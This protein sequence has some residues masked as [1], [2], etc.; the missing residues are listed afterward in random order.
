MLTK[1]DFL[2]AAEQEIRSNPSKYSQLSPLLQAGDP[3]LTQAIGSIATML[4]MLSQ[5]I[6]ASTDEQFNRIKKSTVDAWLASH[7][8]WKSAKAATFKVR[9]KN[10]HPTANVLLNLFTQLVSD[11][12]V[13]CRTMDRRAYTIEPNQSITVDVGQYTRRNNN[14]DFVHTVT[15]TKPFY[16]IEIPLEED[17]EYREELLVYVNDEGWSYQADYMNL[18]P[19]DKAYTLTV[20]STGRLVVQFGDDALGGKMLKAGD[21]VRMNAFTTKGADHGIRVGTKMVTENP[22]DRGATL[23]FEVIEITY[24]GD[25]PMSEEAKAQ[26]AKYPALYDS[27][28]VYLGEFEAM[29]RRKMP[30]LQFLSIWNEMRHEEATGTRDVKN[31]NCLFVAALN[32]NGGGFQYGYNDNARSTSV[33]FSEITATQMALPNSQFLYEIEKII[34]EADD[35]YRVRFWYPCAINPAITVNIE[36]GSSFDAEQIRTKAKQVIVKRYGRYYAGTQNRSPAYP[37]RAIRRRDIVNMIQ[38][39]C[40]E[41]RAPGS[42]IDVLVDDPAGSSSHPNIYKWVR[43]QDITIN[44]KTS[45]LVGV[46]WGE[47]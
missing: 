35:S 25:N 6:E 42:E 34:K 2:K 36:C 30:N 13:T 3:R 16:Q 15:E 18:Q 39:A 45:G 29:V 5:Q 40:P 11:N 46:A 9:V 10:P 32:V 12:G 27:S 8:V 4:S 44:V 47:D 31:V 20:S 24:P 43:E 28:A 14:N 7:G 1:A 38:D 37:N 21:V 17:G 23:E 41:L 19:G 22:F 33:V 26:L